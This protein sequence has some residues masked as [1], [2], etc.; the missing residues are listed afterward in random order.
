MQWYNS[1]R[2]AK[3]P[4]FIGLYFIPALDGH[5]RGFIPLLQQFARLLVN[6][7]IYSF[8]YPGV[9]YILMLRVLKPVAKG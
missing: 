5:L 6:K 9:Y 8:Y 2:K 3:H 1:N 7:F 4:F